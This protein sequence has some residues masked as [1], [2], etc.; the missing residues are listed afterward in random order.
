[1]VIQVPTHIR[2]YARRNKIPESDVQYYMAYGR[3]PSRIYGTAG[4]GSSISYP[5]KIQEQMVTTK[6]GVISEKQYLE[7][8]QAGQAK[9]PEQILGGA[10]QRSYEQQQAS[11]GKTQAQI[12]Q[13]KRISE[14]MQPEQAIK[15]AKQTITLTP[16]EASELGVISKIEASKMAPKTTEEMMT[17]RGGEVLVTTTYT[18]TV[19]MTKGQEH[20]VKKLQK[21]WQGKGVEVGPSTRPVERWAELEQKESAIPLIQQKELQIKMEEVGQHPLVQAS[22]IMEEGMGFGTAFKWGETAILGKDWSEEWKKEMTGYAYGLSERKIPTEGILGGVIPFDI[23]GGLKA[24]ATTALL[25]SGV[26]V[27][28][29]GAKFAAEA[30]YGGMTGLKAGETIRN[31]T[32]E[33]MVQLG[34][35]TA[36]VAVFG[37]AKAIS[38][39]IGY[40]KAKNVPITQSEMYSKVFVGEEGKGAAGMTKILTQ[41]GDRAI[42]TQIKSEFSIG[43]EFTTGLHLLK[44]TAKAKG[45]LGK[46]L[47]QYAG[48]TTEWKGETPITTYATGILKGKTRVG[49]VEIPETK[50]GFAATIQAEAQKTILYKEP[51]LIDAG[52]LAAS[53]TE[54]QTLSTFSQ[55]KPTYTI[56]AKSG[57]FIGEKT[58]ST[59]TMLKKFTESGGSFKEVKYIGESY[60]Y[61]TG[62]YRDV[63]GFLVPGESVIR[64]K[65]GLPRY[66]FKVEKMDLGEFYGKKLGLT[67]LKGVVVNVKGTKGN[68]LKHELKHWLDTEMGEFEMPEYLLKTAK[69]R[70]IISAELEKRAFSFVEHGKGGK[71]TEPKVTYYDAIALQQK[72]TLTGKGVSTG[73]LD[74]Y[75]V[76][77]PKL[78]TIGPVKSTISTP[79][80]T[81]IMATATKQVGITELKVPSGGMEVAKIMGRTTAKTEMFSFLKKEFTPQPKYVQ[82]PAVESMKAE[83]PKAIKL[84]TKQPGKISQGYKP[85]QVTQIKNDFKTILGYQPIQEQA[86][87]QKQ[88]SMEGQFEIQTQAMKR[89]TMQRNAESQLLR[90]RQESMPISKEIQA[91]RQRQEPVIKQRQITRFRQQEAIKFRQKEAVKFRQEFTFRPTFTTFPGFTFTPVPFPP[92]IPNFPVSTKTRSKRFR[93]MFYRELG[94]PVKMLKL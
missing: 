3:W 73:K 22:Y 65:K 37:G 36:P 27:L 43:K 57:L 59:K 92:F 88:M 56:G 2:E 6:Q 69:G 10:L 67:S 18:P 61:Y 13:E 39:G 33:N 8:V 77:T 87:F 86:S 91:I 45:T 71:F 85:M 70:K 29:K 25:V 72:A 76:I 31:P 24:G 17:T 51:R 82:V 7:Q 41:A 4:I 94:H 23:T 49:F 38:K 89:N 12:E 55:Y 42:I 34:L 21:K 79:K 28:G 52:Y 53:R 63:R 84:S 48:T 90:F 16:K 75:R 20:E 74:V 15:T 30:V 54:Y 35:M 64:I 78:E 58:I 47:K 68:V 26:G 60:K 11:S 1:M 9:S 83:L 81:K 5:K 62:K 40:V 19:Q 50:A 44:S 66:V 14:Q 32:L 46:T 80:P 93:D